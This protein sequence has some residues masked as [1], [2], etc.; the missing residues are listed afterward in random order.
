MIV[1]IS[2][3]DRV[4]DF[5]VQ[6]PVLAPHLNCNLACSKMG[7]RAGKND[8]RIQTKVQLFCWNVVSPEEVKGLLDLGEIGVCWDVAADRISRIPDALEII[9]HDVDPVNMVDRFKIKPSQIPVAGGD[10]KR[11]F[12]LSRLLAD[13]IFE[14]R[15]ESGEHLTVIRVAAPMRVLLSIIIRSI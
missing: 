2:L 8:Y 15:E 5:L 12:I 7:Q 9:A 3:Y 4:P 11:Y 14:L 6:A 13:R 1:V 10:R